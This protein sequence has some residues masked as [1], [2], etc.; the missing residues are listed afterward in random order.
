MMRISPEDGRV[1]EIQTVRT[2]VRITEA[3]SGI[4]IDQEQALEIARQKVWE[5]EGEEQE[6]IPAGDGTA[7]DGGVRLRYVGHPSGSSPP[8]PCSAGGSA[9]RRRPEKAGTVSAV[10]GTRSWWTLSAG[11]PS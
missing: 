6:L 8:I 5:E 11:R 7:D 10:A 1:P 4:L 9:C 3:P 2:Q